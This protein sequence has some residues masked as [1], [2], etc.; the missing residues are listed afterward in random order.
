MIKNLR[1]ECLLEIICNVLQIMSK[2]Y[3][4]KNND[5]FVIPYKTY[6]KFNALRIISSK[7]PLTKGILIS[8]PVLLKIEQFLLVW[9]VSANLQNF[10]HKTVKLK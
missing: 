9:C 5:S 4:F 7:V 1:L 6:C 8:P 2:I 10:Y 3:T